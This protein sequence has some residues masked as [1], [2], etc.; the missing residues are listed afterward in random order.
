MPI[1]DSTAPL[2]AGLESHDGSATSS[3]T[4]GGNDADDEQAR[5]RLKRK[6]QRNRTSFTNDQVESLEKGESSDQ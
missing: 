2:P 5:V 4:P 6:L 3:P 1:Y